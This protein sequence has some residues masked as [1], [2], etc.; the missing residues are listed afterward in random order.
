MVITWTDLSDQAK[1]KKN[2]K[3]LLELRGKNVFWN[4]DQN[5]IIGWKQE[6]I[7]AKGVRK[8][9]FYIFLS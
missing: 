4:V 9:T 6:Q 3:H 2:K 8:S 7:F 5:T 1:K